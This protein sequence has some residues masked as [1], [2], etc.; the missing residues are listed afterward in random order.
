MRLNTI[1]AAFVWTAVA[2]TTPALAQAPSAAPQSP[3]VLQQVYACA[4]ITEDAARLACFDRAVGGLRTA[5]SEGQ[6]AAVDR[7]AVQQVEREAF[8]FSLPSLPRLAFP[9]FGSGQRNP[10]QGSVE[11]M[12]MT[13]ERVS[14]RGDGNAVFVMSNGQRWV[15]VTPERTNR[16]RPGG[17]VTIRRAMMGSFLMSVEAGGPAHR[18]RREQ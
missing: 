15:Q 7:A 6:F 9:D 17:T 4:E 16:V 1:T 2:A 12:V 5:Q 10:D 11:E 13:I 3:E 8:G 18:V 14:T